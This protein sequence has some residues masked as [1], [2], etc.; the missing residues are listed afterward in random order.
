[1]SFPI[2]KKI[3]RKSPI[4][5]LKYA[6]I[7]FYLIIFSSVFCTISGAE[8]NNW[9]VSGNDPALVPS[10]LDSQYKSGTESLITTTTSEVDQ[11][12]PAIWEDR[13]VWKSKYINPDDS[14]SLLTE[15]FMVNLTTGQL[16]RLTQGL[17]GVTSLDIWGD[18]VVWDSR[19]E[20][21]SDIY[22]YTISDGELRRI[23]N[24]SVNQIRP[25]I[26]EDKLVWQEG[27]DE[28]PLRNVR[29]YDLTTGIVK[30][31]GNRSIEAKSPAL[32]GDRIVWQ[33]WESGTNYDISLY[34]ITT[35]V[36]IQIT[37]DPSDQITPSIWED[38]IVWQD[39]RN[40]AS[41]LYMYDVKTGIE[42]QLTFGNDNLE[43]P[44][45]NNQSI[46]FTNES[47]YFDIYLLNILTGEQS[48]ISNDTTGSAQV[49]PDIWGD[50]IVWTDARN[51]DY[52]IY[53]YTLGKIMSPLLADFHQNMTQGEPPLTVE[54]HDTSTGDVE[55]WNWDFGDQSGS[56]EK[57]PIH[58][59]SRAGS[60]SVT[61]TVYNPM[62]RNA[63]TKEGLISVGSP[64][65]PEF[66]AN[67]TSGPSPLTVSFKDSSS[68]LPI[69]WNWDF[70]DGTSSD[71][72]NPVHIY[73]VAGKYDVRLTIT[74]VFGNASIVKEGVITVMDGIL[75]SCKVPSQGI[76]VG[77]GGD[78]SQISINI[79]A[80]TNCSYILDGNDTVLLCLPD[81]YYGIQQM[82]MVSDNGFSMIGNDTISGS[83]S[84]VKLTSG[85]K[86]FQNFS[87]TGTNCS[88]NFTL[89]VADYPLWGIIELTAWEGYT[90]DDF[91]SFDHIKT[92]YNYAL[93]DGIA[94]TVRFH[95]DNITSP[96]PATLIFAVS[97][98]WVQ[99]YGW[100]DDRDIEIATNVSDAMIFIDGTYMGV[101]PLV[102]TNL[103]PGEHQLRTSKAGYRET[104]STLTVG[105]DKRDGIHVI[106]IGDDGEGEVLNTTYIGH[107]DIQNLDFFMGE[108]P[109]GLST[110]G[111]ASLSR[112]GSIFQMFYLLLSGIVKGGSSGFGGGGNNPDGVNRP[113]T[114]ATPVPTEIPGTPLTLLPT[115]PSTGITS[116][117]TTSQP[118]TTGTTPPLPEPPS[119]TSTGSNFPP[120]IGPAMALLRNLAVVAV[121]ALITVIFYF[122][123]KKSGE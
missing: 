78:A 6:S 104:I 107:D 10:S 5:F 30:E 84:E 74:N 82:R 54:F 56:S 57:N 93:I 36:E 108:S 83:L 77:E 102:I 116:S 46:V 113:A 34:N 105:S 111:L 98:D 120:D 100:S 13:I 55:G 59:Y 86:P 122:R 24:D 53:L 41:Q 50:R 45:I 52:D 92:L 91:K 26:W 67:I 25:Q 21:Y 47:E 90:P 76:T 80:A 43:N 48:R 109:H 62:Q 32:W 110:F 123:W 23:T 42:T 103:T 89:S 63:V 99:E 75:A 64:P 81:Q 16:T 73:N 29:L 19:E 8:D 3:C 117:P 119:P 49:D 65:V 96:S 95:Q 37:T 15:L 66:T 44:V 22:L 85:N 35:E 9:A 33:D 118:T 61:L 4:I 69:Q 112:S 58:T 79:T 2:G 71:E 121:V 114:T 12:I 39:Y 70:G 1:M 40:S 60:F 115:I 68:G 31:L 72:Q 51:G 87:Q 94:Y 38:R 17:S 20:D 7:L 27:N 88:V 28:D 106:R 11:E 14:E 101:S 97:S 18:H